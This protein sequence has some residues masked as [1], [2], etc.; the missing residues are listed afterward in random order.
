VLFGAP[1][2]GKGTQAALLKEQL[3]LPHIA[4]GDLLRSAMQA[5]TPVGRRIREIVGRGELV[6]DDLVS[7]IVEE[8]L[9]APD[10]AAGFLVDGYPRTVEQ[11]VFLDRL[12]ARR[13][14]RLDRVINIDLPAAEIISRLTGRRIC[15]TCGAIY[16]LRFDPPRRAERCDR[17]Q[18]QLRQRSDDTEQAIGER[19]RVYRSQTEPVIEH[20]GRQGLLTTVDG[21]GSPVEVGKRMMEVVASLER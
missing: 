11:A 17:C 20:Y 13:G 7:G 5:E 21:R 19:L 15:G 4:T 12:V 10:A 1:G 8:R 16:H 18:G 2:V 9:A 14:W 3:A 6:P